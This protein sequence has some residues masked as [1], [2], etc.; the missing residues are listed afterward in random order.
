MARVVEQH[1]RAE[2]VGEDELGR[3]E[4]RAVDVRL[5]SEV[6]DRLDSRPPRARPL[7]GRRCRPCGTRA[8]R[9]RGS[10]GCP[11]YVSLSR[12]TTSSPAP[13]RRRTNCEPM[14][15]AP[16]VT[17]TFIGQRVDGR[18]TRAA[19]RASAAARERPSRCAAR[20]TPG[21]GARAPNS[22]VVMRRTRVASP[23]SSKIASAKSAQVQSPAGG[24]VVDAVRQPSSSSVASAR[25][26]TYVGEPRWSSTTATSSRSAP[27]RSIVRHEVLRRP[28]EQPRRAH[29]PRLL[30]GR[31]LAVQLRPPVGAE[32]RRRVRLD[33]RRAL[34]AVED[35]V[36]RVRDERRAELGRVLRAADVDR[37]RP[38]RVVLGAVDVRPRGGVQ[39]EVRLEAG[40][41]RV[42]RR[43]SPRASGRARRGNASTQRVR[44]AGRRRP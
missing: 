12:T 40:R 10:P 17:R 7:P 29:D 32:R 14:K 1:L 31:R 39:H 36:A 2:N 13:A 5:G 6:D 27:S 22:A 30:A 44:R 43:P 33:V 21:R 16:P 24:D 20:S 23:A 42:R 3:A 4:D 35:V 9:P 28:A 25:C 26:P 38:L 19:P 18:G 11:A 37:R 8:R 34:R 15:P 41:R